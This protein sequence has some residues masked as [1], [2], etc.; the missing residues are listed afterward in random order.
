[1]PVK[2]IP[3]DLLHLKAAKV[4]ISGSRISLPLNFMFQ[5]FINDSFAKIYRYCNDCQ[6][7]YSKQGSVKATV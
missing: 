5:I 7:F 3:R 4:R 6:P 1:M 2:K